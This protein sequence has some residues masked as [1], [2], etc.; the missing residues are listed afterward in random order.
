M[1]SWL[2]IYYIAQWLY[3]LGDID[4]HAFDIN[5]HDGGDYV[6][7][8]AYINGHLLVAQWLFSLGC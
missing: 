5:I 7:H 1:F 4:I 8:Q 3:S 6:F 2:F